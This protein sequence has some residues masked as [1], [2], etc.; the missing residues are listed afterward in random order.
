MGLVT[1]MLVATALCLTG[2]AS[3]TFIDTNSVA[4]RN[5]RWLSENRL[6]WYHSY[7][8]DLVKLLTAGTNDQDD[9]EKPG[10]DPGNVPTVQEIGLRLRTL[11]ARANATFM[12][13]NLTRPCALDLGYFVC[14]A[15]D[16]TAALI[17]LGTKNCQKL[18]S[19]S[20]IR[21][22]LEHVNKQREANMWTSKCKYILQGADG[23]SQSLRIA[24]FIRL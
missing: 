15:T 24:E 21:A 10:F 8:P 20:Q 7:I 2:H 19:M 18:G 6:N 16:L 13:L 14:R 23:M 9:D 11:C 17:E 12:Y 5:A 3:G 22:C 1:W 4:M